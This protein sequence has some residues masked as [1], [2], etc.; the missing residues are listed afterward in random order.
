MLLKV[1]RSLRQPI[2]NEDFVRL[3][4]EADRRPCSPEF[5]SPFLLFTW[6]PWRNDSE[7][8]YTKTSFKRRKSR[9]A[10]HHFESSNL[11]RHTF[12]SLHRDVNVLRHVDRAAAA[13][14]SE[15]VPVS[16]E[17]GRH[18]GF[19]SGCAAQDVRATLSPA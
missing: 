11:S 3:A 1:D 14:L 16:M 15:R 9:C 7:I 17:N 10:R 8:Y 2:S 12:W 4:S 5:S 19:L 6:R 18:F 13:K